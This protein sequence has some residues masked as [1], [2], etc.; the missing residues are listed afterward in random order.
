MKEFIRCPEC[1]NIELATVDTSTWPWNTLIHHC[2][3][4]YTIMESEWW[5]IKAISIRQPWAS[6]IAHGYKDVENRT[7]QTS[8]RGRVLIHTGAI[9]DK[10][11]VTDLFPTREAMLTFM[12]EMMNVKL[13]TSAIIGHVEIIDCVPYHK[14]PWA[15]ASGWKWVLADPVLFP[16]PVLNVRGKLSFFYPEIS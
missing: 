6:L 2:S 16:E 1:G 10:R 14:S 11:P 7:W 13:P 15:E 12:R 9:P 5:K 4:G 3:C 8:F